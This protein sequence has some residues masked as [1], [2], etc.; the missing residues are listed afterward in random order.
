M[1]K[2]STG[3]T[4]RC[5]RSAAFSSAKRRRSSET[6]DCPTR[7]SSA[8]KASLRRRSRV[9]SL[10]LTGRRTGK[11]RP[12]R[13]GLSQGTLLLKISA[14][15]IPLSNFF[16]DNPGQQIFHNLLLHIS[17]FCLQCIGCPTGGT[18]PQS[19][20][21]RQLALKSCRDACNIRIT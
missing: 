7:T 17:A 6:A 9:F 1:S 5:S 21:N 11:S 14:H 18:Q 4:K 13:G 8:T 20:F 2:E 12:Q 19:F 15:N 10:K 16:Y 3:W